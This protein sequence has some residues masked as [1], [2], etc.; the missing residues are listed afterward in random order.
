MEKQYVKPTLEKIERR[1]NDVI[2]YSV[3][4]Q[5]EPYE[6]DIKK[7]MRGELVGGGGLAPEETEPPTP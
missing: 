5:T 4:V 7:V 6:V 2:L 1:L 3:P